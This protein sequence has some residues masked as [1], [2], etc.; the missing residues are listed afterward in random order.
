MLGISSRHPLRGLVLCAAL[1]ALLTT[2][3]VGCAKNV[4]QDAKTGADGKVKGA[5]AITLE[6]NEGEA[7][8]IVT[9]PGGDR[10]D[11][12]LVELPEGKRGKLEVSLS[13]R[14]PRPGLD[15]AFDVYDDYGQKVGFVKPKKAGAAKKSKKKRGKKS[16]TIENVQ[17]K[18]YV[19]IYASNRGDAGKYKLSV[20]FVEEVAEVVEVFD[21][22]TVD[23]PEPPK[24]AAVYLPCDINAIDPSNPD[25]KGK[26]PPC[27]ENKPDKNN[28]NCTGKHPPC[29]PNAKDP[30]NPNCLALY[31]EC[32]LNAIDKTNPKCA[33]KRKPPPPAIDGKIQDVSESDQGSIITIDKGTKAQ[34]DRGWTG[35]I[36][37]SNGKKV[38]KGDFTVYRVTER[39]CFAKVKLSRDALQNYKNVK[40]VPPDTGE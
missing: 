21:M 17:G 40:L 22:T 31:P 2:T 38:D 9:Y 5:K 35:Y 13:W 20:K 37:T 34:V 30:T 39:Q 11:W 4:K 36:T 3:L 26:H 33:G 16:T 6:A 29:D 24:L 15:L 14:P 28:P 8:G 10:V 27:D 32:D 23:V 12:K 1:T 25:C 7:S 18:Y 19:A